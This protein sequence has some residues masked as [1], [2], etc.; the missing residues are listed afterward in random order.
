MLMGS[1]SYFLKADDNY[2][3]T[4]SSWCALSYT[5]YLSMFL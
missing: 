2:Q 1:E 4:V 3:T 5:M